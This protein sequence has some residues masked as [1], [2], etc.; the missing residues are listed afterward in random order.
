MWTHALNEHTGALVWMNPL[1]GPSTNLFC[2]ALANT[3]LYLGYNSLYALDPLTGT[4]L[5]NTAPLGLGSPAIADG[6]VYASALGECT[7]FR[8]TRPPP[9]P[10]KLNGQRRLR[11]LR[12]E[13]AS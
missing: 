9:Q 6:V 10:S 5:W 11:P 8:S 7:R 4:V 12:E 2:L 3:V 13:D 1:G